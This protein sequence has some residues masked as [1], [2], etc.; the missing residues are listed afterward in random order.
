MSHFR[1]DWMAFLVQIHYPANCP[2]FWLKYFIYLHWLVNIYSLC[3]YI[4][5]ANVRLEIDFYQQANS[6]SMFNLNTHYVPLLVHPPLTEDTF[7]RAAGPGSSKVI[8]SSNLAMCIHLLIRQNCYYGLSEL[9]PLHECPCP[10]NFAISYTML[11]L[12]SWCLIYYS[13]NQRDNI[14][15][16]N[17]FQQIKSADGKK[18]KKRSDWG[19][20]ATWVP[21]NG[22]LLA[23]VWMSL[24]WLHLCA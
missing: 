24:S 15:Q 11:N 5:I 12:K 13:K 4:F 14:C 7:L 20:R 1:W 2:T 10:D 3:S 8:R 17:H 18:L 19:K 16:T 9:H 6:Q 23:A 21:M 22:S